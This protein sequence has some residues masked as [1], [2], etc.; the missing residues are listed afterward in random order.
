MDMLY[1]MG[2]TPKYDGYRIIKLAMEMLDQQPTRLSSYMELY[3]EL[4]ARMG[5]DYRSV[6]RCLRTAIGV[7]W[8]T[9][10]EYVQALAGCHLK[11]APCAGSFLS[12]LY[13]SGC[14][15]QGRS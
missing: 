1:Q 13:R 12:M 8:D 6:E 4:G 9:N 11:K 7:A 15:E 2:I 5:K 3:R 14:M 10:P